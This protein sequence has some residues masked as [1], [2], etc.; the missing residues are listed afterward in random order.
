MNKYQELVEN[1]EKT[2]K[3][4][5]VLKTRIS[6]D[7]VTKLSQA[8]GCE[9]DCITV[10]LK[11]PKYFDRNKMLTWDF[12]LGINI[13]TPDTTLPFSLSG[14]SLIAIKD[15]EMVSS[16]IIKY[17]DKMYNLNESIE[18][19]SDI[20]FQEIQKTIEQGSWF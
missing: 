15:S 20:I 7:F 2:I 17:H 4:F 9:K 10:E 16:M 14:F 6:Q 8:W 11:S 18:G 12:T 5:N 19:L 1:V 13:I 3:I